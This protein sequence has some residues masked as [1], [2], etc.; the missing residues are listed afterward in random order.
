MTETK[1]NQRHHYRITD[2]VK[3]GLLQVPLEF[4]KDVIE[5]ITQGIAH[6]SLARINSDIDLAIESV[7]PQQK[8]TKVAL[9][10]INRKLDLIAAAIGLHASGA[11][12]EQ[13]INLS[14]GGCRLHTEQELSKDEGVDL[15]IILMGNQRLRMF[16]RVV[17]VKAL[18]GRHAG[19][20]EVAMQFQA[21]SKSAAAML[22]KHLVKRQRLALR[23]RLKR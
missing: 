17:D 22:E 23:T 14:F 8:D 6:S 19:E 4:E 10:A 20:F 9:K 21:M 15:T 2:I 3:V 1:D 7:S 13:A 12:R 16:A 5:D 18:T 11:V